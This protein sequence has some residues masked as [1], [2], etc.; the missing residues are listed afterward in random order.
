MCIYIYENYPAMK[1]NEMMT[2]VV[3]RTDLEIII[4]N[5][6][7]SEKDTYMVSLIRGI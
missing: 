3:T 5:E 7:K 6:V 4:L 2:F 1:K